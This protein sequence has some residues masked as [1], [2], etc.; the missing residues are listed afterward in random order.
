MRFCKLICVLFSL[1]FFFSTPGQK[2]KYKELFPKLEAKQ[3]EEAGP[4]LFQYLA[5]L[6]KDEANPNLQVGLMLE[7]QFNQ[8]DII[9]DS[10]R[11]YSSGDSAIY[12]LGKAKGLI[13]EKELRKNDEYYQSFFRRDLRTGEF[14]IKV[15]D[16][17]LDIEKKIET[18]EERVK[19]IKSL[20]RSLGL[21]E[22]GY[23]EAMSKYKELSSRFSDYNTFLLS[24]GEAELSVLEEIQ[25]VAYDA[26][27]EAETVKKIAEG[28]GSAKY[29]GELDLRP[30][31]VFGKDGLT[32]AEIYGSALRLW[33]YDSWARDTRS[34]I[35]GSVGLFKT[36]INNYATGLREKKQKLKNSKDA[37]ALVVPENLIETFDKYD[38]NSV[39][40]KLLKSETFE[41]RVIK[42]VDLQINPDLLDSTK[43]GRQLEIY[44]EAK[45]NVDALY[46]LISSIA[47]E[48]LAGAKEK[49][50][51]YINSFF[52]TYGTASKY[53]QEMKKW[54]ARN[55]EWITNS[56]EYWAERNRWGTIAKEGE[57]ERKIPLY[58]SDTLI[59][60]FQVYRVNK[61]SV[62]QV[63]LHGIDMSSKKG[64]ILSFGTD[65]I[66]DWVIEFD[67]PIAENVQY[68]TDTIPADDGYT[69]F[70]V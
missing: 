60:D 65:R 40:E 67:L 63:V 16:V 23:A 45:T 43:I 59:N 1:F 4:I 50:P 38:P 30:I 18:I 6:K 29:Q 37:D 15:S 66:N 24:S 28:L 56:V 7:H 34:E 53:I 70:Y 17:H 69:G 36:M 62:E 11:I 31:V 21:I 14:G 5:T 41:A 39:V 48:D 35:N 9:Y 47:L 2:I 58:I 55:K 19:Q 68:E 32:D 27:Q 61:F 25:A 20:N 49:Y 44:T 33:D 3:Y 22:T 64:S 8:F 57:A 10:S 12:F 52:Q 51:K 42:N 46:A 54:S 26:V 13:D